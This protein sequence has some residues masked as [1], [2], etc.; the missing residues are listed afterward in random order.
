MAIAG[1]LIILGIVGVIV[2]AIIVVVLALNSK[3]S[4]AA[5]PAAA[6]EGSYFDGSTL[7]LIGYYIL[8]AL[9]TTITLGIAYPWVLCMVQGWQVKHTVIN[10]RRLKFNGHGH[11]LIGK[12][13]LWVFLTIITFGIYGIWLGLGMKKW[14]VK[15]T[16]YADEDRPVESYFSGGAGGF[17]GV[18]LLAALLT[19]FTLG[20]GKAWADKMVLQWEAKHT[21]IGGSPLEFNGTGGQLFVKYLLFVLLTP[22]TLGIYALFFPVIYLK[23]QMKHTEAVYQTQAIQTKA[24]EHEAPAIQ[25]FAK[26]RIAANDQEIAA[27]K[28]GYTG[29][30]DAAA[31]ERLAEENNP[32][33]AYHLAKQT[34]GEAALYE[35]KA[36][37]LLQKSAEGKVHSALLDLAKQTEGEQ[38]IPLLT[39]AAQYGNAEASLLLADEYINANNLPMGAYWFK[40]AMEWDVAEATERAEEYETL[41]KKIALQLSEGRAEPKQSVVLPIVLGVAGVGVLAAVI[42]VLMAVLGITKFGAAKESAPAEVVMYDWNAEL[43]G[44]GSKENPY[45]IA[46]TYDLQKYVSYIDKYN[47]SKLFGTITKDFDI[48][49][50]YVYYGSFEDIRDTFEDQAEDGYLRFESSDITITYLG[51]EIVCENRINLTNSTQASTSPSKKPATSTT[52]VEKP[53]ATPV[54]KPAATPAPQTP[55]KPAVNTASSIVGKWE[56][57]DMLTNMETGEDTLEIW[58]F[59]FRADGTYSFSQEECM[60]SVEGHT[61]YGGR[62]W[63]TMLGSGTDGK[64]TLNGDQLKVEYYIEGADAILTNAE[65]T[66]N[67]KNDI[68]SVYNT[69]WVRTLDFTRAK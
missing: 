45:I 62:A 12:Y 42:F 16:F 43:E 32:F 57:Y 66:V 19:L 9:L 55:S 27:M 25:D 48:C 61:Y 29:K 7:Q 17:L 26:Y 8:S 39:E 10:G 46:N 59:H 60:V 2:G 37:E 33:A 54:E 44:N 63:S 35:G 5:S 22:L 56:Y 13:L 64:Y 38:K 4:E 40:V 67:L 11:Q 36:L 23:W 15:H 69:G 20:I 1:I 14:V 30:E 49:A 6:G 3:K 21:H 24:R 41:I 51:E 47:D 58:N 31:L 68:L 53:A 28:S 50:E 65:Y 34:K 18:H 52:P